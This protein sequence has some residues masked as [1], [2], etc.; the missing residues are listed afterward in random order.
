MQ[1]GMTDFT[2]E[3]RSSNLAAVR[4]YE[5]LG[6]KTEGVRSGFYSRPKED[7]FIMWKH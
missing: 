1:M 4:L 7:A 3:V 2:L 6:F 5:K